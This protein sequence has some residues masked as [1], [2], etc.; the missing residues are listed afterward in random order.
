MSTTTIEL[1]SIATPPFSLAPPESHDGREQYITNTREFIENENASLSNRRAV[2][3]IATVAG[4]NFLNTMGSGI[5]TVALPTIG[6]DLELSVE[7]L[8]WPASIHA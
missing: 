4:V 6:K 2:L 3:L 7:L 1:T 8:L 5:L